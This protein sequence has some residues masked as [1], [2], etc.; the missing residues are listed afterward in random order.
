MIVDAIIAI[1]A[2]LNAG[3]QR[4]QPPPFVS[5]THPGLTETEIISV[6]AKKGKKMALVS[7]KQRMEQGRIVLHH[8][9]CW[10][11]QWSW[12]A[13]IS[14]TDTDHWMKVDQDCCAWRQCAL[15]P[16]W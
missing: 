12:T 8:S 15:V 13:L 6:S 2:V 11:V 5:I 9:L 14:D 4:N 16:V 1:A 7:S 10:A 3:Q